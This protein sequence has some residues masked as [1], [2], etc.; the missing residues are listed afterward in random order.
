MLHRPRGRWTTSMLLRSIRTMLLRQASNPV[1]DAILR[2]GPKGPYANI[3]AVRAADKDKPWV[4]V[5][6]ENHQS[7]EIREFVLT[8][9][10][11]MVV[12]AR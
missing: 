5:L 7:P 9:F 10:K 4:K 8:K 6:V 3:I 11:G 12:P 1:K 2:E